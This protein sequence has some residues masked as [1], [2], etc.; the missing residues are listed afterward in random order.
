MTTKGVWTGSQKKFK[1]ECGNT[2]Y[3]PTLVKTVKMREG[4][5]VIEYLEFCPLCKSDKLKWD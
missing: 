1:C 4:I 5:Q 2:G 3:F